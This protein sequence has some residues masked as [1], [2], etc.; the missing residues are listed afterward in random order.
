MHLFFYFVLLTFLFL[1]VAKKITDGNSLKAKLGILLK[2]RA[3][4][5]VH[6]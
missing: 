2:S 6:M 4:K 1:N 3:T 5:F